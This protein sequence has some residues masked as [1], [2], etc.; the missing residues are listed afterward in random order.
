MQNL[1][2]I[3]DEKITFNLIRSFQYFN[4]GDLFVIFQKQSARN[5]AYSTLANVTY[6]DDF[7]QVHKNIE[8]DKVFVHFLEVNKITFIETH[9]IHY[10][11]LVWFLWGGDL[12]NRPELADNT[13]ETGTFKILIKTDPVKEISRKLTN[14]FRGDFGNMG[15]VKKF[16]TNIDII[17]TTIDKDQQLADKIFGIST[18][19]YP[20]NFYKVDQD[21]KLEE[22]PVCNGNIIVGNSGAPSNN[23]LSVLH[24]LKDVDLGGRKVYIPLSY[25]NKKYANEIIKQGQYLL[26]DSIAPLQKF[27]TLDDYNTILASC[28]IAIYNFRRQ[29]G[30]GNVITMLKDHK[31]VYL[32]KENTMYDFFLN[33]QIE[34]EDIEQLSLQ[35]SNIHS[36]KVTDKVY[37]LFGGEKYAQYIKNV[38]NA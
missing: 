11:K 23:H 32:N 7:R 3:N 21:T 34:V 6:A 35:N 26:G 1:H 19:F 15:R 13:I 24:K 17:A 2:L 10:R 28:E 9:V 31:K 22:K 30:F 14:K 8:F 27:M 25:G 16:A 5:N 37:D 18:V 12:Y 36:L 20:F 33:N 29:Q 4:D 38:L